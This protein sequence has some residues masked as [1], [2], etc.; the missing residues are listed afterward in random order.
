M[1][2]PEYINLDTLI[3][4]TRGKM[5]TPGLP[6]LSFRSS[7]TEV[8]RKVTWRERRDSVD[9]SSFVKTKQ[10]INDTLGS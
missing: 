6:V 3:Q 1:K 9:T 2:Y 4:E 10:D 8:T 7:S 5:S